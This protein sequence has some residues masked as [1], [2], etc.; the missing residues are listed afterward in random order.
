V[1]GIHALPGGFS[2]WILAPLGGVVPLPDA[3]EPLEA[4]L[5]EP[6]AAAWHAVQTVAILDGDVVAVLGV[7]RLGSLLVAALA[8]HR[9]RDGG[10]FEIV[11][12]ARGT[13]GARA[14]ALGADRV[15]VAEDPP[16]TGRIADVVIEATG[17]PEGLLLALALARREVHLKSTTGR[18]AGGLAHATELVVDELRLVP[19]TEPDRGGAVSA[20]TSLAEIDAAIRPDPG[21]ERSLVGPRGAIVVAPPPGAPEAVLRA[22]GVLGMRVT[23][24]RCG[25]F[26]E[27]LPAFEWLAARPDR[28][29]RALITHVLPAA[30]LADGYAAAR[31]PDAV[32]VVMRHDVS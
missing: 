2:P 32:K 17:A 3:L 28:P 4:T 25:E 1:L 30:R 8:A 20:A 9:E 15:L 26:R 6:F 12:V 18:P 5:L 31:G 11:A 10:R 24:S 21:I 27:A 23:S 22:V 16:R 7:G 13:A 19:A 14:R 29:L